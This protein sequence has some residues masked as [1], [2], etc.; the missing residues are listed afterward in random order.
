MERTLNKIK[1]HET[2]TMKQSSPYKSG[3]IL[4][5]Y[6]NCKIYKAEGEIGEIW[7]YKEEAIGQENYDYNKK[8]MIHCCTF[9]RNVI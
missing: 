9:I 4:T 7:H 8:T 3:C 6:A 2:L 5:R 1:L